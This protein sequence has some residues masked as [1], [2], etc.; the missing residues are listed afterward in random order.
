[1]KVTYRREMKRN[2]LIID[3]E[4][5]EWEGYESRMLS[6]NVVDGLLRIQIRQMES[7]V[8]FYYDITSR[9]PLAR[10]LGGPKW[11]ADDLRNLLMGIFAAL[12]HM[13]E[14]LLKESRIYLDPEYIYIDPDS[15]RVGLCLVPG[16]ERDFPEDFGHLLEKLLEC[17][18]HQDKESV[19][20]AYGIYQESR[21][22]NYG[23]RDIKKL[24][25]Q[26]NEGGRGDTGSKESRLPIDEET[27]GL[28][29][30][31]FGEKLE[32]VDRIQGESRRE[33]SQANKEK[34]WPAQQAAAAPAGV[35]EGKGK[36][37]FARFALCLGALFKKKERPKHG[38]LEQGAWEMMF[39]PDG[40][41]QEGEAESWG[42]QEKYGAGEYMG[43]ALL[44]D[45][46]DGQ[47]THV[48]RAMDRGLEDIAISYY[49]FIIGKQENLVDYKLDRDTVSR[50]HVKIDRREG[51]CVVQDLNST[52]GT[53]LCGRLLEN[54]ETSEIRPGDELRIARYRYRFE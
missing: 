4:D 19:V 50:L 48:L 9:Q 41:E 21:K 26:K 13:E 33:P 51:H 45:L 14:Y 43:T 47:R 24:L 32:S 49:P 52:N 11:K 42:I 35:V 1:M 17:V 36:G 27:G 18:D 44:A 10:M 3:P 31:V 54:N 7:G 34:G 30:R 16:M 8:H 6:D 37:W 38:V 53:L 46:S 29:D 2:Y 12:E 5:M 28:E 40:Q 20:L 23:M 22:I 25:Y 39:L 15:F